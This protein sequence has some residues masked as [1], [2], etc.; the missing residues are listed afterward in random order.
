MDL[1]IRYKASH[2]LFQ[3]ITVILLVSCYEPEELVRPV[4]LDPDISMLVD[5]ISWDSINTAGV[6]LNL[7]SNMFG[8]GFNNETLNASFLVTIRARDRDSVGLFSDYIWSKTAVPFKLGSYSTND[9]LLVLMNYRL[10]D[11]GDDSDGFPDFDYWS[12][13]DSTFNVL[14]VED[15]FVDDLELYISGSLKAR[16]RHSTSHLF[17]RYR[18]IEGEFK[19]VRVTITYPRED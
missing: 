5:N 8:I 1:R 13:S 12:G 10:Y 11:V 6:T 18:E 14:T 17:P 15:A 2:F 4:L 19:N 3:I 7:H 16:V 9:T